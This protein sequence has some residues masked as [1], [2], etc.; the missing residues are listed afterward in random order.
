MK[1][2]GHDCYQLN[3]HYGFKDEP[4]MP[5]AL[6]CA[7]ACGPPLEMMETSFFLA[8][9]TLLTSPG[10]AWRRGANTCSW[11]SRNAGAT[12]YFQ[13]PSNRVIELGTQVEI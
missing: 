7:S 3:V 4:D 10:R 12:E 2:L 1:D 13:M 11:M 6:S 9:Q 8:R 5:T